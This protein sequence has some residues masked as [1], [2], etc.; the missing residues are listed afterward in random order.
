MAQLIPICGPRIRPGRSFVL[1]IAIASALATPVAVRAD[2]AL[3]IEL[4]GQDLGRAK[5]T[6]YQGQ[7]L[8]P[9][10]DEALRY[11]RTGHDGL[12]VQSVEK[13]RRVAALPKR[14]PLDEEPEPALQDT[15]NTRR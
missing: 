7:Q 9:F 5:I 13:A 10:V 14:D 2:C 6:Q 8:A 15:A 1:S 11:C 12:A 3:E 4:L